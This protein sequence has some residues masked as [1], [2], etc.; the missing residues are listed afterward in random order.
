MTAYSEK[1]FNTGESIYNKR[2]AFINHPCPEL[3]I[4]NSVIVSLLTS[5][6]PKVRNIKKLRT[7]KNAIW[8]K[9]AKTLIVFGLIENH[10]DISTK[11]STATIPKPC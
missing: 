10:P 4:N 11:T 6:F 2:Y 9:N 3:S 1:E 7:F 8:N 5:I